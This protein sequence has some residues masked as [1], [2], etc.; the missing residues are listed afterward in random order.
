MRSVNEKVITYHSPDIF[1][2]K[3]KQYVCQLEVWVPLTNSL[4]LSCLSPLKRERTI[5]EIFLGEACLRRQGQGE[6]LKRQ[7]KY[8]K[9]LL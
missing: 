8:Q 2:V 3:R 6:A 9:K 1:R 7:K 4:C 5:E